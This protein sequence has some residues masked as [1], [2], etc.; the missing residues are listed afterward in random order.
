M[1]SRYLVRQI[2]SNTDDIYDNLFR[3]RNINFVQQFDT[4]NLRYPT[5]EEIQSLTVVKEVWK[6]G[7]RYWKYA[8]K[9]YDNPQMWWVIGW[10]NKKPAESDLKIGDKVLIPMPLEKILEYFNIYLRV[11]EYRKFKEFFYDNDRS[12]SS[13]ANKD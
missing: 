1:T 4:A 2:F 8:A 5:P 13:N 6:I 9:Y 11:S 10:F 7:D 3:E 12:N